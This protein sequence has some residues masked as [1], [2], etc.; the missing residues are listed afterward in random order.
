MTS[1]DITYTSH[2]HHI[3]SH[4]HTHTHRPAHTQMRTQPHKHTHR[5]THH[6]RIPRPSKALFWMHHRTL[7][8]GFSNW[9]LDKPDPGNSPRRPQMTIHCVPK[10]KM[11]SMSPPPPNPQKPTQHFWWVKTHISGLP[12]PPPRKKRKN[13]KKRRDF[14][15]ELGASMRCTLCTLQAMQ[16][17][18]FH[19]P[20]ENPNAWFAYKTKT[21]RT[22]P[23]GFE[24][25]RFGLLVVGT[26]KPAKDVVRLISCFLYVQKRKEDV[27]VTFQ[28]VAWVKSPMH[29]AGGG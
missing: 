19:K 28:F 14:P 2:I 7:F 24:D 1:H 6:T 25:G 17:Q 22:L 16:L 4:A 13:N 23:A 21:R 10:S 5:Q 27:W 29:G 9:A 20:P 3:T 12:S 11:F 8:V 26:E 15:P 18:G